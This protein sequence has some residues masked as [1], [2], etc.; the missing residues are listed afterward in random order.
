MLD[1]LDILQGRA[2]QT[3]PGEYYER[4]PE[5]IA[6]PTSEIDLYNDVAGVAIDYEHVD[7][8]EYHYRSLLGNLIDKDG[9]TATIKTRDSLDYKVGGY[10][11]LS[12]GGLYAIVSV[13]R[14][15]SSAA[16]Q[17][18]RF[19]AVPLDTEFVLRLVQVEN[20]RGLL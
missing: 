17:A 10:I 5:D 2:A 9:A 13:T 4:L 6:Y 15:V 18:M 3:N 8:T 12:D 19:N 14:D 7:P 20:P 11:V 16:K 1:L